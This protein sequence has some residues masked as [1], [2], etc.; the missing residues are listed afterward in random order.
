MNSIRLIYNNSKNTTQ[1][2]NFHCIWNQWLKPKSLHINTV[3]MYG[4]IHEISFQ[5]HSFFI[6]ISRREQKGISKLHSWLVINRNPQ[7]GK[8]AME[9]TFLPWMRS[10][11]VCKLGKL[12]LF[13]NKRGLFS[14]L[15]AW[16]PLWSLNQLPLHIQKKKKK[17]KKITW[18]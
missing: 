10:S 11:P 5:I 15:S 4:S 18:N 14:E 6:P 16:Y 7:R 1:K 17:K 2:L 9:E 3:H 13:I 8:K 12:R